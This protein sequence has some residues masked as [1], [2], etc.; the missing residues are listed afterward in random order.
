MNTRKSPK[1]LASDLVRR[2]TCAIRVSAVIADKRGIFSWG[3]NHSGLTGL[4]EHAEV[5]AIKRANKHRLYGATIY[6]AGVYERGT[7]V[8]A[9]PC[10]ACQALIDKYHLETLYRA[11]SGKWETVPIRRG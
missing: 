5:H 9:K 2:S 4:G 7:L 3:H 11:K 1:I 6:V 8:K 10:P